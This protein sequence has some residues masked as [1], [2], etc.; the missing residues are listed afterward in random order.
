MNAT[1]N[2]WTFSA[3]FQ[4]AWNM[5]DKMQRAPHNPGR[6]RGAHPTHAAS[7]RGNVIRAYRRLRTKRNEALRWPPAADHEIIGYW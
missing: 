5:Q 2:Q 1:I 6:V 4:V 7:I 3:F